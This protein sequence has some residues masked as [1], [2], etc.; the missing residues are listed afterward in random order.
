[1]EET[2]LPGRFGEDAMTDLEKTLLEALKKAEAH[3]DYIGY[4][5]SWERGCAEEAHLEETIKEAIRQGE[6]AR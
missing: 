3:L 6:L 4:G 2:A 1:M 5:D